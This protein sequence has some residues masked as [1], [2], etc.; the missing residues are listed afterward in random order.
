MKCHHA[1]SCRGDAVVLAS[2]SEGILRKDLPLCG[3]CAMEYASQATQYA[4]NQVVRGHRFA[5]GP[6]TITLHPLGDA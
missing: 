3:P 1:D 4:T 6:I 5:G 2:E